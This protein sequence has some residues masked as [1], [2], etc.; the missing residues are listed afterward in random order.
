MTDFSQSF[1]ADTGKILNIVINS[2]YSD[3]DIFLRELLSNASD[4]IQKRNFLGQTSKSIL[5]NGADQ[6]GIRVNS[7]KKTLEI[8]DT[9]VGLDEAD[10]AATLGTIAK[11]GTSS[12]LQEMQ[13]TSDA[14]SAAQT[15]IGKFGVGFYSAFMI[16]EKVEV[17]TKKAGTDEVW[18][19][20]SDGQTGYNIDKSSE[21]IP[22]GTVI[23]MFLKKDAKEYLDRTKIR[24]LIQKYSDHIS[25][26]I[27]IENKDGE[28]EQVNSSEALWTRPP[29]D[30]TL[31]EY[32]KFFNTQFSTY[33]DPFITLHNKSEGTVE[34][35]NL[36][37]IPS[38]APFDLFDAERKSKLNLY[39]NRVFITNDL[40]GILPSWLRFINGILDTTSLDLN[41]S[42]EMVQD[43]PV[44]KKISKVLIKRILS[45]L[46]KK[47]NKDPDGYD[48]FWAQ[49]GKVLKEGLYEDIANR[50]KI[51]G[52]IRVFS[53]KYDKLITLKDYSAELAI[54]QDQI[55]YLTSETL[56][57]ARKSPHLEGF[58]AK[59]VD[60]LLMT[61]PIDA[62]WM[63][64]M[65]KFEDKSFTSISR[66]KYD[67]SGVG[68]V[69]DKKPEVPEKASNELL[70]LIKNALT[71]KV[72]DVKISSDLKESPVRLVAGQAG[73]DYNLER[74]LKAQNPTFEA[75]KKILEVNLDHP[76]IQKM[77]SLDITLAD[78]LSRVL[79]EQARIADGE[80]PSDPYKFSQDLFEMALKL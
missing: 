27:N 78:N 22:V 13:E 9:G 67:L 43:S 21:D 46:N 18:A 50:D 36:M 5:N 59:G 1:E 34:F 14:K 75:S 74:I 12:F 58:T 72:E 70:E 33:D 63:S 3:R 35:T 54:G 7:K 48:K 38:Q 44:I 73:L 51:A 71:D 16:A 30:I 49:F 77:I 23:R 39:I 60:V 57:Q 28:T 76:L 52:I 15:L 10:L 26:P 24:S 80:M 45:E 8:Q 65:G 69:D 37:F 29:Q 42:R 17:I 41:V 6:I 2:L 79:F 66:D 19:W 11:S 20:V 32:T 62:F 47:L 53:L 55:F 61:D 4:A 68:K 25:I 64:Q 56:S 40:D 31:E